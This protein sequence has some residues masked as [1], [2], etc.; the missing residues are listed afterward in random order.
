MVARRVVNLLIGLY[1]LCTLWRTRRMKTV[2]PA[3][4]PTKHRCPARLRSR[5]CLSYRDGEELLFARGIIVTYESIR[6]WSQKYRQQ[7]A[8]H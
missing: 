7:F 4:P 8:N 6:L 3:N 1:R 2:M 5:V